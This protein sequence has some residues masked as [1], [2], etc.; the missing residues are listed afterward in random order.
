MVDD[1][2]KLKYQESYLKK[3]KQKQK[4]QNRELQNKP[5]E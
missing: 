5:Q 2:V 1:H 4:T 3:Q